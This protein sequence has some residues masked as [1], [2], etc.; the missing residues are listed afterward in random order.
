MKIRNRKT[1]EVVDLCEGFI[2][3]VC[4]GEY[5]IVKPV[6]CLNKEYRY[7]SWEKFVSEWE[8][9]EKPKNHWWIDGLGGICCSNCAEVSDE[10]KAIGNYFESEEEAEKALK[11]LKALKK[12]K[13]A[14]VKFDDWE[15]G[16]NT[17]CGKMVT[18]TAYIDNLEDVKDSLDILFGDEG[19]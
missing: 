3:D 1:G 8:E 13:D 17:A 10:Q 9:L 11:V 2:G 14:G 5:I 15:K 6:A 12:L 16:P 19:I 18:A 7:D 4:C